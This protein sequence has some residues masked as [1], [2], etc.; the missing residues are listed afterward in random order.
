MMREVVDHGD[1]GHGASGLEPTPNPRKT[2]CGLKCCGGRN[3]HASGGCRRSRRVRPDRAP[4]PGAVQRRLTTA[5]S[6]RTLDGGRLGGF[7]G[8]VGLPAGWIRWLAGGLGAGLTIGLVFVADEL[9]RRPTTASQ[10]AVDRLTRSID[11]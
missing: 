10:Y 7:I 9:H 8:H 11:D 4:P 2:P 6:E 3:T 5:P 1:L